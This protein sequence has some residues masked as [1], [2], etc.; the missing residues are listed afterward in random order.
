MA[1]NQTPNTEQPDDHD[2]THEIAGFRVGERSV[3][4]TA[5]AFFIF[6]VAIALLAWIPGQGF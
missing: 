1:N 5:I 6:V 3:P 4:L 2:H